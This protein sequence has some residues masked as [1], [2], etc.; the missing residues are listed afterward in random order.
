MQ[1]TLENY[2]KIVPNK[3]QALLKAILY[4]LETIKHIKL[5]IDWK[6][7]HDEYSPERT[8]PCPDYYGMYSIRTPSNS[9]IGDFMTIQQL[10]DSL[11]FLIE[12]IDYY[13]DMCNK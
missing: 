8:D 1:V 13:E 4:D 5:H 6:E 10:D 9:M 7:T 2:S 11:F 12:F 3:E